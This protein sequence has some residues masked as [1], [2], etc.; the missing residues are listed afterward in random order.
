MGGFI[1]QTVA[2]EHADRVQ[3]LT[4]MMTSTGSRRVGQP[5]PRVYARLL[6]RRVA[7]DRPAAIAAA[8]E[9]FR[10][11]GSHGLAFDEQYV[12]DVAGRSW[13]RG[14]DPDGYRRQLAASASQPNRSP[15]RDRTPRVP[16]GRSPGTAPQAGHGMRVDDRRA[17]LSRSRSSDLNRTGLA[18]AMVTAMSSPRRPC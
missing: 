6:R 9:T 11:I 5:K 2:L 4:L 16:A 12:G 15:G 8:V 3:T 7:G 13:D 17:Y 1:A 14:Y 18:T 10:L